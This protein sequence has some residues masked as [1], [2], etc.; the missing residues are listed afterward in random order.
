MSLD[1]LRAQAHAANKKAAELAND[2]DA[3]TVALQN[4]QPPQ[5][6]LPPKPTS[7]VRYARA[8]YNDP[9]TDATTA[10]WDRQVVQGQPETVKRI[11]ALKQAGVTEILRYSFP[12]T[13]TD[14]PDA[15]VRMAADPSTFN[16]AWL[17]TRSS[18]WI[19]STKFD[20]GDG[21]GHYLIDVGILAYQQASAVWLIKRCREDGF[22]GIY[23]DE[24]NEFQDYAGYRVPGNYATEYRFQI[25]QTAYITSVAAALKAEGFSCH[26]NLAANP[27]AWRQNVAT[28]VDGV[29]MEFFAVQWTVNAP[30]A[31]HVASIENKVWR[32]QLDWLAWNEAKGK[33]TM[34]QADARSEAQVLYALASM[35]LVSQGH[36]VFAA[37]KG[38]YGTGSA[39]WTPAMDTAKLLGQ[40]KAPYIPQASGL[41]TREFEHGRVT[42][43]PNERPINTM[44]ATSG[45]IELR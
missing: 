28:A 27:T 17:A 21:Y 41:W 19:R 20:A 38:G 43:N 25:A 6:P 36:A 8:I 33:S 3:L 1:D 24:I 40:P 4:Y 37:T 34:C 11:P 32:E 15:G 10:R 23:L 2:L 13:W 22:T 35:L 9:N 42:V 39:W 7:P 5:P 14:H 44:P 12:L 26:V 31:W 29:E 16:R 45:L 30:D 18:Q